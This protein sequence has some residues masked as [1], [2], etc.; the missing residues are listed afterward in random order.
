M[1]VYGK[2]I[3]G[4]HLGFK[5]MWGP[6]LYTNTIAI[7]PMLSLGLLTH[8]YR[9][10]ARIEWSLAAVALLATS[11]IIGVAISFY[12]WYCRSLITAT[13]Y[14]VLGVANKMMTVTINLLIWD[15]HASSTG[16]LSLVVCLIAAAGYTQAPLRE[17]DSLESGS[18]NCL[19]ADAKRC[20]VVAI[21]VAAFLLVASIAGGVTAQQSWVAASDERGTL[22]QGHQTVTSTSQAWPSQHPSKL[23]PP[24]GVIARGRGNV[25]TGERTHKLHNSSMRVPH[26]HAPV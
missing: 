25:A 17:L 20:R 18:R 8:E 7:V 26:T 3:V 19:S 16:I 10:L 5:S 21:G 9:Q 11:C 13:C 24:S 14:T 6:T 4:P 23:I 1:G 15:Q 22:P 12:G 2:H